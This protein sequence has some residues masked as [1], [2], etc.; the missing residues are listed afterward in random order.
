ME[1]VAL[2]FEMPFFDEVFLQRVRDE[3]VGVSRLAKCGFEPEE[4]QR[5]LVRCIQSGRHRD[6]KVAPTCRRATLA[7]ETAGVR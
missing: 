1:D 6:Q 5:K 2:A 3:D 4:D 7:G